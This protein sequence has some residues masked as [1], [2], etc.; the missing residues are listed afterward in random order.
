MIT[1]IVVHKRDVESASALLRDVMVRAEELWIPPDAV[2]EALVAELRRLTLRSGEP[3]AAAAYL[4]AL[5]EEADVSRAIS[6]VN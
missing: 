6:S 3:Q 1:A 4:R 2:V 5:A